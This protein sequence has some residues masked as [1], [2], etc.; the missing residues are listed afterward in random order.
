[1]ENRLD[2]IDIIITAISRHNDKNTVH[3]PYDELLKDADV[4][5]H[6]CTV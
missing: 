3:K 1:M 2:E 5:S 6:L 4:M